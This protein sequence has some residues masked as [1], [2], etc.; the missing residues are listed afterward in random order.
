MASSAAPTARF[1]R[2]RCSCAPFRNFE[3]NSQWA[4]TKRFERS[5]AASSA[6]W[7][8]CHAFSV[9]TGVSAKIFAS[10]GKRRA[11]A[12]DGA[13]GPASPASLK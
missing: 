10:F 4:S 13:F 7:N 5:G 12:D 9:S 2:G 1:Q 11:L 8:A 6:R 3:R